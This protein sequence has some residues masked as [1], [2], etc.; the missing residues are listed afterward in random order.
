MATR[1]KVQDF[2][3]KAEICSGPVVLFVFSV[4]CSFCMLSRARIGG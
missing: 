4:I 2:R 1:T 3:I